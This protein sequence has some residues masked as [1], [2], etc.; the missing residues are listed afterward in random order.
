M[1]SAIVEQAPDPDHRAPL[2][3]PEV[4]GDAPVLVAYDEA[5]EIIEVAK[6][7]DA[8]HPAFPHQRPLLNSQYDSASVIRGIHCSQPSVKR[9]L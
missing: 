7:P 1:H 6:D 5:V 8:L 4:I 9:A 2:G 3:Q